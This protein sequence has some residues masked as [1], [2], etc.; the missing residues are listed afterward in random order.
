MMMLENE[1]NSCFINAAIQLIDDL[2]LEVKRSRHKPKDRPTRT[3]LQ[4]LK[5]RNETNELSDILDMYYE[6]VQSD[7]DEFVK[8]IL[9]LLAQDKSISI[10]VSEVT[11]FLQQSLI[12]K[13]RFRFV[14]ENVLES[15]TIDIFIHGCKTI[16]ECLDNS[17]NEL[18]ELESGDYNYTHKRI[19]YKPTGRDLVITLKR[20]DYT[21]AKLQRKIQPDPVITFGT[22]RYDLKS[23]IIHL[24]RH[25]T[26]GHYTYLTFNESGEPDVYISD[27]KIQVYR[28]NE[29]NDYTKNGYIYLY[30]K[31][32]E[33]PISRRK[34]ISKRKPTI[35]QYLLKSQKRRKRASARSYSCSIK[36]Y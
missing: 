2:S 24:G 32:G 25:L 1:G 22:S 11:Q 21:G 12:S 8:T 33:T 7:A 34:K 14:K 28:K 27:D 17:Q 19:T 16:Q 10:S 31:V 23:C 35:V 13:N 26:S 20:Y 36:R 5:N 3:L 6:G 9:D 4:L 29:M 15:N 30:K 18:D